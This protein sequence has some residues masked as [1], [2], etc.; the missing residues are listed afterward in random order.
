ML[1]SLPQDLQEKLLTHLSQPDLAHLSA[2]CTTFHH[3]TSPLLRRVFRCV[4]CRSPLF[5]PR[6]LQLAGY[7]RGQNPPYGPCSKLPSR[8]FIQLTPPIIPSYLGLCLDSRCATAN[9]HVLRHLAQTVLSGAQFP[10]SSECQ[11]VHSLR[12]AACG[13][14]VGFRYIDRGDFV[15]ND[16]IE[17]VNGAGK[18]VTLEGTQVAEWGDVTCARQGC[19][20]RLF[21]RCDVLPWT[22]VLASSRLTDLDAYLEWELSW[23]A[24][25]AAGQ[26]AFFVR[27]VEEGAACVKN[28]RVEMMRQGPMLVADLHCGRCDAWLGWKFIKEVLSTGKLMRN[29]DQEGRYGIVRNAVLPLL[30]REVM[31]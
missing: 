25:G 1:T 31:T 4:T 16:L 14:F 13:V 15:H 2:S 23:A 8:T 29:Y 7:P 18:A 19:G 26:P 12:C 30:S 5:H 28:V 22:H 27:R 10:L 3:L 11:T 21:A 17:L 24:S 6:N 20:I 9:F